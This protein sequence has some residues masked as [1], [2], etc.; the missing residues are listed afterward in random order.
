MDLNKCFVKFSMPEKSEGFDE[1]KFEWQNEKK[2]QEWL[3]TYVADKKLTAK[4]EDLQ[5]SEWFSEKWKSWQKQ[6]QTWQSKA[7]T[8]K[9][10]VAKKA[11]DKALKQQQ[12]EQ[13]KKAK[14][15]A[16]ALKEKQKAEK[17]KKAEEA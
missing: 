1:M 16:K 6:T 11:A 17:A 14:E 12:K 4:V 10:A 7:S 9:A 3:S 5:V 8:Y 15:A 13:K 2:C